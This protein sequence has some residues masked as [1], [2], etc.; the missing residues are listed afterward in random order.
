LHRAAFSQPLTLEGDNRIALVARFVE[1]RLFLRVLY[2]RFSIEAP[3]HRYSQQLSGLVTEQLQEAAAPPV[4]PLSPAEAAAAV[5]AGQAPEV[6][7]KPV[8]K[9]PVAADV[10]N[11]S[12]SKES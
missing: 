1:S 10:R 2:A 12:S 3:A 6:A 11:G 5:A 9:S 7:Q 4:T 8:V